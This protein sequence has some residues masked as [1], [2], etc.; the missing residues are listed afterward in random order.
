MPR[1][2]ER[3]DWT[4]MV[5]D[6]GS[7]DRVWQEDVAANSDVVSISL[8]ELGKYRV[9]LVKVDVDEKKTTRYSAHDLIGYGRKYD[10]VPRTADEWLRE[11][12]EGDEA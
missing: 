6:F 9:F 11:I 4:R 7:L 8:P 3:K 12:R 10:S 5:S 1:L 2:M